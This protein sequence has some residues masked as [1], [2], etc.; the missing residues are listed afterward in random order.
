M[1]RGRGF[2]LIEVAIVLALVSLLLAPFLDMVVS[3]YR[4]G[5]SM[6]MQADLKAEAEG[7]AY[8]L[9]RRAAAGPYRLEADNHGILFADGSRAR[10]R[11]GLLTL[12]GQA[13]PLSDF[14]ATRRDGVLT[15]HLAFQ[16]P[17][18]AGG[19]SQVRDF[20]FDWPAVG[21]PR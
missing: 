16:A 13:T 4:E 14:T 21:V 1:R 7:A 15:L 11:D 18:H 12:E 2:T 19:P 5:R 9:F 3:V 10:F 6:A 17:A 20:F 8:R